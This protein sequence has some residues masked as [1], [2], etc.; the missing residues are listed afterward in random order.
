MRLKEKT[1][2]KIPTTGGFNVTEELCFLISPFG[3]QVDCSPYS[4][5]REER[6]GD[7]QLPGQAGSGV[8]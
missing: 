3:R 8:G 4:M 5:A 2:G 6:F 1:L 7:G